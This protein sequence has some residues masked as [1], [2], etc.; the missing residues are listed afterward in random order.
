MSSFILTNDGKRLTTDA[1]DHL[2]L[3]P[4]EVFSDMPIQQEFI[5]GI[6]SEFRLQDDILASQ[7][8]QTSFLIADLVFGIVIVSCIFEN[9]SATK[10]DGK[11]GMAKNSSSLTDVIVNEEISISTAAS[12]IVSYLEILSSQNSDDITT[13]E[14]LSL[15]SSLPFVDFLIDENGFVLL[16][17]L[18]NK[19]TTTPTSKDFFLE[20]ISEIETSSS[21]RILVTDDGMALLTDSGN[22]LIFSRGEN[23]IFLM[24]VYSDQT[25]AGS[26]RTLMN[27]HVKIRT[28]RK[29]G[30]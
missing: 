24:E 13:S 20:L 3:T 10:F 6:N 2:L 27:S 25:L 14:S 5:S 18:G 17:E 23:P 11:V 8:S 16:D 30:N 9:S 22:R 12:L 28:L 26:A 4:T 1:G 29:M 19:L 21:N 7:F 15:I